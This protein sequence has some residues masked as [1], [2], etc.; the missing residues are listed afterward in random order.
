MSWFGWGGP[1]WRNL[2]PSFFQSLR[3]RRVPD[4]L[5]IYFGGNDLGKVTGVE[6]VARMKQ[7]L[8]R[9]LPRMKIIIFSIF[10]RRV[11]RAANPGG[12][13]NAR[14]WVNSVM[15]TFVRDLG[16]SSVA[17]PHIKFNTPGLFL[18]DGVHFTLLGNV[19]F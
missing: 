12:I 16:G 10:E 19:F 4:V 1:R 3:G 9:Q 14:K 8:H 7:D 5:L 15:A 2:L 18:R 13:N 11:W 6:L 17:H